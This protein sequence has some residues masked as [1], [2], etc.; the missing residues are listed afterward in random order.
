MNSDN[1]GQLKQRKNSKR[2]PLKTKIFATSEYKTKTEDSFNYNYNYNYNN[3]E[4]EG[5]DSWHNHGSQSREKVEETY[6]DKHFDLYNNNDGSQDMKL[7]RKATEGEYDSHFITDKDYEASHNMSHQKKMSDND[8]HNSYKAKMEYSSGNQKSFRNSDIN[9]NTTIQLPQSSAQNYIQNNNMNGYTQTLSNDRGKSATMINN[10]NNNNR[11]AVTELIFNDRAQ[12]LSNVSPSAFSYKNQNSR[13]NSMQK[14]D[15]TNTQLTV[16][17][18]NIPNQ[19]QNLGANN[20][21]LT[22][23]N[24]G[25]NYDNYSLMNTQKTSFE[26]TGY[27]QSGYIQGK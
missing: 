13:A 9:P 4:N 1:I 21:N 2:N 16:M 19:V 3:P 15:G 11:K 8:D 24:G 25:R 10:N 23:T 26:K 20:N 17:A 22:N 27:I 6:P 12:P 14:P 7:M 18:N 5:V